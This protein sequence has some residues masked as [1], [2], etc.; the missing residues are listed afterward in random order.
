MD[1]LHAIP[2]SASLVNQPATGN[3]ATKILFFSMAAKSIKTSNF[4]KNISENQGIQQICISIQVTFSHM[5]EIFTILCGN[6][7]QI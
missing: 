1:A 2:E 6:R 4:S 5:C 3:W 7:F